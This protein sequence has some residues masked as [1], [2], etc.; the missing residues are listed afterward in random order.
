MRPIRAGWKILDNNRHLL[1]AV[2][3]LALVIAGLL[4]PREIPL[5]EQY[6]RILLSPGILI[7]DFFEIGG[8]SVALINSG[9]LGLMAVATVYFTGTIISGPTIAAIF[10]IAGFAMFG[11]T[12]IN[13]WPIPF[14]VALS[15]W[16]R[17]ENFRSFILAALFGTALGPVVSHIAFG[18]GLGYFFGAIVGIACGIVLPGLASHV[19]HNHQGFCLYNTGF[20]CGIIGMFVASTLK[21]FGHETDVFLSWHEGSQKELATVFSLYLGSM[22]LLGLRGAGAMKDII[23][24]PGTMVTDFVY[25]EGIDATLFNMGLTGLVGMFFIAVSGGEFNGPTLGGV[26]TMVGFAAFGKHP[27]N[28]WPIMA[29]V[30][31]AAYITSRSLSDPIV[32][33]AGLFGTTLAPLAG[34]FGI[35]TGLLAGFIHLGV[36]LHVGSFHAGMNLYN[37]GFAGGLVGTLFICTIRWLH[38]HRRSE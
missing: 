26:F 24:Q 14:G 18:L 17:R 37:N 3:M 5:T 28:V 10:T 33:L 27:A 2:Y 7:S 34:G 19:L 16:I 1:F 13:V 20:T 15:A 21:M 29:G 6:R 25:R 8:I 30:G 38:L 35:I 9:L 36:V 22:L 32:V 11:K 4:W 31:L 23:R 12:P